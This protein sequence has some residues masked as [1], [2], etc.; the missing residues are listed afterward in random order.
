MAEIQKVFFVILGAITGAFSLTVLFL[1]P[2]SPD[3][4]WFLS[5]RERVQAVLRTK[6]N[7]AGIEN[8]IW[9][10]T[11]FYEA[12]TDW[13]TWMFTLHAFCQEIGNG[14]SSQS[15]LIIKS[16][17]Y[18]TLE[19]TLLGCVTGL[20]ALVSISFSALVLAFVKDF[21]A[22]IAAIMYVPVVLSAVLSHAL[23]WA[24]KK[25]LLAAI[26]LRSTTGV[27]YAVVM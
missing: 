3:S 20:A 22:Y 4:A 26:Y 18:S 8:K 16:F 9:K 24:D 6:G 14:F 17:G 13:K 19:T 25:G 10:R 27:P 2:D 21:R 5:R 11:Q 15:N 7:H 12:L 1:F 23:S